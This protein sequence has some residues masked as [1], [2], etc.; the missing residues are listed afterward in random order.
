MTLKEQVK[1]YST[2]L[3]LIEHKESILSSVGKVGNI[4]EFFTKQDR[5]MIDNIKRVG[6]EYSKKLNKHYISMLKKDIANHRK[7]IAELENEIVT[8]QTKVDDTST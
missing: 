2:L 1:R 6:R 7:E 8:I 3:S 5:E 4:I